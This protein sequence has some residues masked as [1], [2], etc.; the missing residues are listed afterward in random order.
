MAASAII[1]DLGKKPPT[2]APAMITGEDS[3]VLNLVID[4]PEVVTD[5][6]KR[7]LETRSP[8]RL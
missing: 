6:K 1:E 8:C 7:V 5:L 3:V 4:D 2:T